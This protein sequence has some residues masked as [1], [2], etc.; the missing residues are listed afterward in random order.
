MDIDRHY[1][2]GILAGSGPEAG[3]DMWLAILGEWRSAL[4]SSFR[5]DEDA[6]A[7]LIHSDPRLGASMDLDETIDSIRDVVLE[8]AP[9]FDANCRAWVIACN[10]INRLA[11]DIVAADRTSSFVGFSDVVESLLD[12]LGNNTRVAL[13]GARPVARL[14]SNSPY[15]GLADRLEPIDP[16]VIDTVHELILDVKRLG[17][18]ADLARRLDQACVPIDADH[19]L[20]ACTELPLIAGSDGRTIDVTRAVAAHVVGQTVGTRTAGQ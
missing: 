13:L 10:T 1:D 18:S 2:I 7:V 15:V 12:T 20:L 6:P 3:A 11:P 17:P 5:G 9:V 4:G 16:D 8:H 14:G 19:L